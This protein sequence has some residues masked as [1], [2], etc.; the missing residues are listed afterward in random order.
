VSDESKPSGW[1]GR[2]PAGIISVVVAGLLGLSAGAK[3]DDLVH[4]TLGPTGAAV[5][6]LATAAAAFV[7]IVVLSYRGLTR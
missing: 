6:G 7:V 1:L 4:P 3:V 2:V 5:A